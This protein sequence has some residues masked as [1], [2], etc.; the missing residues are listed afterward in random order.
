MESVFSISMSDLGDSDSSREPLLYP[1]APEVYKWKLKYEDAELKFLTHFTNRYL[2][3]TTRNAGK[4]ASEP[5]GVVNV[6][7]CPFYFYPFYF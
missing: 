2:G 4:P 6:S 5:R 1:A 3:R 7:P